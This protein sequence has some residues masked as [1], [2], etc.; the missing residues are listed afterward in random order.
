MSQKPT[1]AMVAITLHGTSVLKKLAENYIEADIFL[2]EK[3]ISLGDDFPVNSN[4]PKVIDA[5][6]KIVMGTLFQNYDL[7]VF[8]F[9]IGAAVRLMAPFLKSKREDPGVVV[10]DDCGNFVIPVLSGHIGGANAFASDIAD[11]I[12]AIVVFTTASESRQTLPVD[13]L[14]RELGWIVEAPHSN[15]VKVAAHVVNDEPI[16][17]IQEAGSSKWWPDDKKLPGNIY[18]FDTYSAIDETQFSA[19]LWVTNSEIPESLWQTLEGR[20]IVYRPPE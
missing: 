17:F 15:Q 3:F 18:L 9:S 16:A 19:I 10:I 11:A 5:P 13:I 20:L 8:V 14:G 6:I 2:S 4:K 1:I 12:D 7:L